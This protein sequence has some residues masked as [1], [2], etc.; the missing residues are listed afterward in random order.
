MNIRRVLFYLVVLPHVASAAGMPRIVCD[1]PSYDFGSRSNNVKI[2]HSFVIRNDGGSI[3]DITR[4]RTGC[5][6]VLANQQYSKLAPGSNTA[7]AV[8]LDLRGLSGK[9]RRSIYVH[10]ND[11]TQT[12]VRLELRGEAIPVPGQTSVKQERVRIQLSK[13]QVELQPEHLDFGWVK[14]GLTPDAAVQL[15][16]WDSRIDLAI[17][18]LVYD[19]T[20]LNVQIADE[21][22]RKL[23]AQILSTAKAGALKD[24]I[25]IFTSSP[26]H[27]YFELPVYGEILPDIYPTPGEIVLIDSGAKK[28]T[29]RYIAVRS[30]SGKKLSI[31]KVDLPVPAMNLKIDSTSGGQEQLITISNLVVDPVL[32]GREIIIKTDI[33]DADLIRVP[34]KV[35]NNSGN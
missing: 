4:V 8:K 22:R 2:E 16:P 25:K 12:I 17:T 6:C 23:T 19:A 33:K 15:I 21:G 18:N 11:P 20:A 10:S 13:G 34:I 32:N 31:E 24:S 14:Q 28:E 27:P 30:R 29:V 9:Q 5:G 3:L 35:V 26:D 1:Q 7:I